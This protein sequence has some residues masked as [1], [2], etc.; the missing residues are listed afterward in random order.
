MFDIELDDLN[1]SQLFALSDEIG[2]KYLTEE[3]VVE[4]NTILDAAYEA[5]DDTIAHQGLED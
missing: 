1:L 3:E 4:R 2:D 5:I